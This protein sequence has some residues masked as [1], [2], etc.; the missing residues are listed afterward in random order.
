M[1]QITVNGVTVR[2]EICDRSASDITVE[3]IAPYTGWRQHRHI[4][5]L[6]RVARPDGFLDGDEST[7][8][9]LLANVY[10]VAKQVEEN[11]DELLAELPH[12]LERIAQLDQLDRETYEI[13]RSDLKVMLRSGEI[14]NKQ[15][16][17]LQRD[18]KHR[19][20]R[21]EHERDAIIDSFVLSF[22]EGAWPRDL[23]D[24]VWERLLRDHLAGRGDA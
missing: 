24:Q 3:I 2:G 5:N 1:I 23:R 6:A 7:A 10:R 12:Y 22:V 13:K 17:S 4:M 15:H 8:K 20:V 16:S 11:H 14:D 9:A 18:L 21:F 19:H